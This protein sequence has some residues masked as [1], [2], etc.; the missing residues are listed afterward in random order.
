MRSKG[1]GIR[2]T[3]AIDVVEAAYRIE[4]DETAWTGRLLDAA[5]SDL[6]T[7]CGMYAF[8]GFEDVPHLA[9]A[10]AFAQRDLDPA[11]GARLAELNRDP[12]PVMLEA[13]RTRLVTCGALQQSLGKGSPVIEQYHS[14]MKPFAIIDGFSIFARDAAGGNI[15]I[16]APSRD[17]LNVVPRVRGIWRRVG[18]H[19]AS[20]LRLR[21]RLA[22][23]STVRD[24]LLDP[25]G[26]LR[27]AK[28]SIK[29][30]Q[31]ARGALMRAVR[32]MEQ[33][34]SANVRTSPD[35]AL[36]LWQGLVAGTWSLIEHWESDGK[37]YVAAYLNRPEVRD[38][39]ALTAMEQSVLEYL[40]LGATNKDVV[41]AL[42][43]PLGTVSAAI[44]RIFEKLRV[45]S[46][47]E[48]ALLADPSRM[49]RLDVNVEDDTIGV[50]SVDE[51]PRGSKVDALSAAELEVA[52][53]AM[54]AWSN[55]RIARERQVSVRTVANQLR[56]IYEKLGVTNRS[57][58]ARAMGK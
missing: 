19:I 52:T 31:S 8:T 49:T 38:P 41:Y 36:E 7:G 45:K 47:A 21:R 51:R 11:Y 10:P 46:R 2:A 18:L 17:V 16:A 26:K 56:A 23:R 35:D 30:D 39:R 3:R 34:R 1:A 6:D 15:T 4:G 25:S 12:P 14:L 22:A 32:A 53:M 43:I 9:S 40:A 54:R 33:A 5:R 24:A 58:L 27:D 20:G 37:R 48:L 55:E 28:S 57:Q 42:G 50:L 29:D 44:V 13:L